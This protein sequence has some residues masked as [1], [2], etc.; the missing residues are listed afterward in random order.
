MS[1]STFNRKTR[2]IPTWRQFVATASAELTPVMALALTT[3]SKLVDSTLDNRRLG[4]WKDLDGNT[5][6]RLHRVRH[7]TRICYYRRPPT[8]RILS[9]QG[10]ALRVPLS[11]MFLSCPL[12]SSCPG[13]PSTSPTSSTHPYF[14]CPT[15]SHRPKADANLTAQTHSN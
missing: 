10:P 1:T 14:V 12:L 4:L 9:R 2:T 8:C 11:G 13:P 3:A 5:S 15:S 7:N 6:Y